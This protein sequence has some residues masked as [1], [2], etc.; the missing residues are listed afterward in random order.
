[1]KIEV[2][3]PSI[4]RKEMDAVLTVLVEEKIG[5]GE[6]SQRLI[7]TAKDNLSFDYC[8]ALRSPVTALAFALRIMREAAGGRDAPRGVLVSALSPRY[9][10]QVISDAGL[11]PVFCDVDPASAL[12]TP[13]TVRA[14]LENAAAPAV[15]LVIHETL[16]LLPDMPALC[17]MGLPVIEDCSLS[18]GALLGD[19]KAGSFGALSIL[20]LEE[21]DMLTAGGGA[22]LFAME[23]RNAS[24][25]RGLAPL[26]PEYGLPDMNAAMA[27]IQFREAA[28]SAEKRAEIGRL[29]IDAAQRGGR[30]K[31]L[32]PTDENAA[33]H[34][35]FPLVLENGVKEVYAYAKKK[36]IGVENAFENTLADNNI[37][38]ET[39]C[40][41]AKSLALRTVRFPLYSRLDKSSAERVAKLIQTLP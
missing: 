2:H 31:P 33:S 14:A 30:H 18:Y 11:S 19:R 15:C 9:Y 29:Y 28:R 36:E 24:V 34:Y 39:G 3:S 26:P 8:L 40:I 16:G 13:E 25:L 17:D 32:T 35:A 41:H 23:R 10:A 4:K 20:G 7:Q 1:M 37:L 22:L 27:L 6:Q 38:P 21:R 5:P 12:V